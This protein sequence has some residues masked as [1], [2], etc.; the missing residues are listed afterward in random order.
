MESEV[1]W[2]LL[3]QIIKFICLLG[4]LV[5]RSLGFLSLRKQKSD[6]NLTLSIPDQ[7]SHLAHYMAFQPQTRE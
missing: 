1:G 5:S 3:L 2:N 4:I 6:H 7:K